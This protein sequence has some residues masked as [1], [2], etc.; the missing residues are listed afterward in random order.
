MALV[1]CI[2]TVGLALAQNS[3]AN[4]RWRGGAGR[5]PLAF[6]QRA[7]QKSGAPALSTDQQSQLQSLIQTYR[8]SQTSKGPDSAVQSA[9]QSF[10]SAVLSGNSQN[11]TAAADTL[12]G[13]MTANAPKHLEALAN[14]EVQALA[15]L[16]PQM[17]GLR[18]TL[19]NDRLL[20]LLGS[21]A[22]GPGMRVGM[23]GFGR[24]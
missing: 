14:F 19:G 22:G 20:S 10:D 3:G 2:G 15:I 6:L 21:L 24:R 23:G 11:A 5:D 8:S 4:Q 16:Q 13:A 9:R 7:I 12:A 17:S 18:Q 1:F